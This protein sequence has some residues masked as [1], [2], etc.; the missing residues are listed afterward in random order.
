M[1]GSGPFAQLLAQRFRVAAKRLGYG[2]PL[3]LDCS[4]FRPP[5]RA[6]EQ[7]GLF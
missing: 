2:L 7:L 5:P 3:P 6:G 1:T 4:R